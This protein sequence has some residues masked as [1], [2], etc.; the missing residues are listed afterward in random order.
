[1]IMTSMMLAEGAETWLS[2]YATMAIAVHNHM[3]PLLY[4]TTTI[5]V[6]NH[7][8]CCTPC[9]TMSV[10]GCGLPKLDELALKA[11]TFGLASVRRKCCFKLF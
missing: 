10:Q 7:N 4:T 6:H 2:L 8:H 9:Q 11:S 1:M 5:A 3:Q